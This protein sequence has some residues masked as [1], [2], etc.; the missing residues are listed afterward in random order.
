MEKKIKHLE[1]IQGVITRM[2]ANLFLL[3]GWAITLIVALFTMVAKDFNAVYVIYSLCVFLI[4]WMLDG[5]FLSTERCFRSLYDNVRKKNED[6]IDFSMDYSEFKKGKNKWF[7]SMFSSTLLIFYGILLLSMTIMFFMVKIDHVK[8]DIKWT[9][10][11][12][13]TNVIEEQAN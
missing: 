7:N 3:K 9:D 2:S 1:M 10:T 4:F 8:L 13:S 6:E 12:D 11:V 5:Y